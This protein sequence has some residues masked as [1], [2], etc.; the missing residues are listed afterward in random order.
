MSQQLLDK[1]FWPHLD[2]GLWA[3][4]TARIPNMACDKRA[5]VLVGVLVFVLVGVSLGYL[6]YHLHTEHVAKAEK[7]ELK[8]L[9]KR[10]ETFDTRKQK[11]CKLVGGCTVD[12]PYAYETNTVFCRSNYE[13][14]T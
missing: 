1:S 5:L 13:Q 7:S 11:Y 6:G 14:C 10:E 9:A 12:E 3:A 2:F 8:I 4:N